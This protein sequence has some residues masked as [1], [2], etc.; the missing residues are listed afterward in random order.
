MKPLISFLLFVLCEAAIGQT[1]HSKTGKL[2]ALPNMDSI[3]KGSAY[4]P[5]EMTTLDGRRLTNELCKGKV[6]F[7][8][9][10][11]E[12]CRGCREEF[13]ELNELYDSLK[14]N[15]DYIFVGV[16][17][18]KPETL[19][20]FID[21]YKLRYPIASVSED[22]IKEMNYKEGF[23]TK[24]IIDKNGNIAYLGMISIGSVDNPKQY[25]S[26]TIPTVLKKMNCLA[27]N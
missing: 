21:K 9:F 19:P 15:P 1:P 3:Y 17:F 18:D 20:E 4:V 24:V 10:W 2:W 5:F 16:T 11:F 12:G 26:M 7:M 13:G 27:K 22:A 6:V 14:N 23:P 25:G 8:D